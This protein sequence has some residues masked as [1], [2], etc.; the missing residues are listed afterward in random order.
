MLARQHAPS[1]SRTAI[2]T[3]LADIA[4]QIRATDLVRRAETCWSLS[5]FISFSG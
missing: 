4:E 1:G 5:L 2:T 3:P